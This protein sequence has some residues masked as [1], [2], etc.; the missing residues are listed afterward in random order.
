MHKEE[1][2]EQW[3]RSIKKLAWFNLKEFDFLQE[4]KNQAIDPLCSLHQY[5]VFITT[6][7]ILY[8]WRNYVYRRNV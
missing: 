2:D 5:F 1:L 4:F 8:R 7:I 6:K 3:A